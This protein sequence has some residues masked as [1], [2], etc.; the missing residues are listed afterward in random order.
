VSVV[1]PD[2]V[3]ER[4]VA[5]EDFG[6]TRSPP[7]ALA[8]G[9]PEHNAGILRQILAGDIHPAR[10]ALLLNAAASLA[11]A[12]GLELRGARRWPRRPWPAE[13]P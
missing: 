7:G 9:D 1:T 13:P 6:L 5:P 11:I 2:A 10:T 8:G 12:R 3:Q 4:V